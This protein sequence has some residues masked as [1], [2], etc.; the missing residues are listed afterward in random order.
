MLSAIRTTFLGVSF[1][2]DG[3][4]RVLI[5]LEQGQKGMI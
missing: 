3:D 4:Y 1:N 5:R 2:F